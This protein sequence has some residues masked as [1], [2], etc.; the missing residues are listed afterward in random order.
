MREAT[1]Q[2]SEIT[3]GTGQ[4]ATTRETWTAPSS[5]FITLIVSNHLQGKP[6]SWADSIY[7]AHTE[8]KSL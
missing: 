1:Q 4:P 6:I 8:T 3:P 7:L 2:G 5:N